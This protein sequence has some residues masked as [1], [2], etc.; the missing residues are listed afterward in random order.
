M[1]ELIRKLRDAKPTS[2]VG[3]APA[4][5]HATKDLALY[6]ITIPP[7]ASIIIIEGN[8][9]LYNADTWREISRLVDDTWFVDVDPVLAVEDLKEACTERN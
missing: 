8:W 7:S 4:F 2:D 6:A 9:F 1:V 3:V 5:D